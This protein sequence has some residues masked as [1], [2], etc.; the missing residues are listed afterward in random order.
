MA[1]HNDNGRTCVY[2]DFAVF[3]CNYQK[4]GSQQ[5]QPGPQ[6]QHQQQQQQ[7]QQKRCWV[8][9]AADAVDEL[10]VR[11]LAGAV[12][13]AQ[14][15]AADRRRSSHAADAFKTKQKDNIV[16]RSVR[17][18]EIRNNVTTWRPKTKTITKPDNVKRN[19]W[20]TS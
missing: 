13:A 16:D 6:Q 17:E 3:H 2:W 18:T 7:Q 9:L 12:Q 20:Y 4:R 10:T 15:R 8:Y 11:S 1:L 14:R 5:Q 19:K